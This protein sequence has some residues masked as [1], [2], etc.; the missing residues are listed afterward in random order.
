MKLLAPFVSFYCYWKSYGL[1]EALWAA[2]E[3]F[4]AVIMALLFRADRTPREFRRLRRHKCKTCILRDPVFDT[5]GRPGVKATGSSHTYGCW[6]P[7]T[8][9]ILVR[10]KE[11]WMAQHGE[12]RW[13]GLP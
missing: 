7:L 6:C 13:K 5:C 2:A 10:D 12:D 4:P 3:M 1:R 11:C 9:A 8:L